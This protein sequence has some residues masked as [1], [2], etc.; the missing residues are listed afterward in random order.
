[1]R[2]IRRSLVAYFLLLLALA[3]GAVGVLVHQIAGDALRDRE[4][5]SAERIN[6]EYKDQC[7]RA[8]EQ[9]NDELGNQAVDLG[10]ELKWKYAFLYSVDRQRDVDDLL[11]FRTTMAVL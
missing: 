7:A 5:I 11:R 8:D 1:M 3:L 10:R 2:S 4:A 9:F 6:K